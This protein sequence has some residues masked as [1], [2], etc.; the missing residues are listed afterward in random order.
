[1]ARD[2]YARF[3]LQERQ[4]ALLGQ[5]APSVDA[6]ALARAQ[7]TW[8]DE[9]AWLDYLPGWVTG[10]EALLDELARSTRWRKERR[11]MYDRPVDVPRPVAV[12]PDDGPGHPLLPRV[13]E[14]LATRYG[15]AFPH[16]T[17]GFYRT[18]D[19]SVAWHGDRVARTM[20]E[21]LVATV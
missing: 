6:G 21:A 11:R 17:L 1:F 9:T 19:D 5:G 15:G 10:H 18:G 12:L 7:R 8:L 2:R 13:Q 16:V 3:V 4:I 20:P 14:L